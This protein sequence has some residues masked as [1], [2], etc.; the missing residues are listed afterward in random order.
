M[1]VLR[2]RLVAFGG[3]GPVRARRVDQDDRHFADT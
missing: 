1:A 3:S 2:A